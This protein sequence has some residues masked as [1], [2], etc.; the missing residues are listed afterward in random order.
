MV[1]IVFGLAVLV[2]LVGVFRFVMAT[3]DAMRGHE[4]PWDHIDNPMKNPDHPYW[5]KHKKN[6][7][8]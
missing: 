4:N 5:D 6:P 7:T 8:A 1:Q 3:V 2:L